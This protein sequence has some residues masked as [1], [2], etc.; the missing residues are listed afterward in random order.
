MTQKAPAL[1]VVLVD[2]GRLRWFVA[3]IGLDGQ[4]QP[5]IRSVD[6]DLQRYRELDYD[7]QVS[8]LRHRFCG[9]VQR[10]CDR[11]WARQMKACHFV[12]VFEGLLPDTTG[13][14]TQ[15]IAEHFALWMINPPVVVYICQRRSDPVQLEI[16]AGDMETNRE[17]LV[18]SQ[19]NE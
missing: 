11:L 13:G 14:L 8:F 6:A 7:D 18:R 2:S 12:F 19:L 9:V 3:A 1:L 4:A 15:A 16:L 10:G 5:L 17:N